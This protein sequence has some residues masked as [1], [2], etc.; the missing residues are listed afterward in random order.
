MRG[1][2]AEALCV[3]VLVAVAVRAVVA[4]AGV[5]VAGRLLPGEVDAE[6]LSCES[7]R[8]VPEDGEAVVRRVRGGSADVVA[9]AV[10]AVAV[11]VG[12]TGWSAGRALG[13]PGCRMGAT[14]GAGG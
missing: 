2:R 7:G 1:G 4:P 3:R 13:T 9:S 8:A 12:W 10:G 5:G 6:G 14:G 11:G